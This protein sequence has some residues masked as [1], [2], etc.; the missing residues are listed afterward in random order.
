MRVCVSGVLLGFFY[1]PATHHD[2]GLNLEMQ[3][4]VT[5]WLQ[6]V[7]GNVS[8]CCLQ[9]LE[10]PRG[11]LLCQGSG[12]LM[13]LRKGGFLLS[14]PSEMNG[15]DVSMCVYSLRSDEAANYS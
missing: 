15:M 7:S 4:A 10:L 2:F 3:F 8:S 6:V 1:Y 13:G 12:E 14:P 9:V 11:W 5:S